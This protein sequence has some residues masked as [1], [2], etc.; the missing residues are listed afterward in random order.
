M[1]KGEFTKRLIEA[2]ERISTHIL[3]GNIIDHAAYQLRLG[4]YRG[5]GYALDILD[6]LYKERSENDSTN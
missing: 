4:E 6:E 2:R 5:V 1:L 3:S